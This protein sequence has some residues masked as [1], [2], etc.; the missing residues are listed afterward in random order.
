MKSG[1]IAVITATLLL[2]AS[3]VYPY[4]V[5][6]SWDASPSTGVTGY[7]VYYRANYNARPFTTST[8]TVD[9]GESPINVGN[10]LT[11][12]VTGIPEGVFVYFAVTAYDD[13]G[14]ES[15]YSNIVRSRP[16]ASMSIGSPEETG[17]LKIGN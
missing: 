13:Q 16:K 17:S 5:T 10:V 3:L 7:N 2:C 15:D 11:Y 12:Q 1:L 8:I 4:N 6:L 14:N 9:G